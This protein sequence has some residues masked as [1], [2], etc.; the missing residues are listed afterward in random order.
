VEKAISVHLA[1]IVVVPSTQVNELTFPDQNFIFDD[2]MVK[3][4]LYFPTPL[5]S[6]FLKA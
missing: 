2:D 1:D 4:P 5:T 3:C 6:S